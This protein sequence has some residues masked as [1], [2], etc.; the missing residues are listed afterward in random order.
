[1]Y[2]NVIIIERIV[3]SLFFFEIRDCDVFVS[4]YAKILSEGK[5][6]HSCGF[7][8]ESQ[9][10]HYVSLLRK[11]LYHCI[12]KITAQNSCARDFAITYVASHVA[13][14]FSH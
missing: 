11:Y 2:N 7:D 5:Q 1:M 9:C 8:A 12:P 14:I 4:A 6:V 13:K 10:A 3:T